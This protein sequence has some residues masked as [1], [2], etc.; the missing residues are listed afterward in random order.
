MGYTS[1]AITG[2]NSSPP[3]DDGS[4]T[5]SN[6]IYWSTIKS[7]LGDPVKTLAESINSA[8]VSAFATRLGNS[9][10]T[11]TTTTTFD[12]N[13]EGSIQVFTGTSATTAT[14]PSAATVG[15]DW[16]LAVRNDGS[17]VLTIDG[18]GSETISGSLTK[19]L[20]AGQSAIIV[21]DGTNWILVGA[22]PDQLNQTGM[23][24][25]FLLSSAP[26]GW[27]ALDRGSIGNATSGA[28]DA[29]ATNQALF[30]SLHGTL[31]ETEAPVIEASAGWQTVSSVS[32]AG[33]TITITSHGLLSNAKVVLLDGGSAT[34]PA[35]LL[36]NQVY[37]VVSDTADTF[38]LS[39]TAGPGSAI[40]IT[41]TGS[42][43]LKI[44]ELSKATASTDF[45]G[46]KVMILPDWQGRTVIGTGTGEDGT[47]VDSLTARSI[48]DRGGSETRTLTESQLPAH[49]HF[50][51]GTTTGNGT[52]LS[53]S[54]YLAGDDVS[55][56]TVKNY[57]LSGRDTVPSIGLT[58]ET[59]SG[60]AVNIMQPFAAA[61]WC[62]KK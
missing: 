61:L 52:A 7:K 62:V 19:A 39:A 17:A 9:V 3:D 36:F 48:G 6:R 30:I 22:D 8:V 1:Q 49:D 34:A 40:N 14:L 46:G 28:D 26:S 20:N 41:S 57:E 35:G 27:A 18:S 47:G 37:Y 54:N 56:G 4:Q 16:L 32:A 53:S 23:I 42:G 38:K 44:A 15:S 55:F 2:Y 58:S 21:S 12:G 59:G 13:D 24:A 29:S 25:P 43:T 51:A 10:S 60:S 33:D 5:E 11:F 31:S 45:S 50:V